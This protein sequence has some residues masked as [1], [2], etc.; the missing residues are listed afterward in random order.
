MLI[1][2]I[3][4]SLIIFK[5]RAAGLREEAEVGID[6]QLGEIV[7]EV[8]ARWRMLSRSS[9]ISGMLSQDFFQN[10]CKVEDT[11]QGQTKIAWDC[12]RTGGG[13]SQG[14][15]ACEEFRLKISFKILKRW[16]MLS[17][18]SYV[19]EVLPQDFS[20]LINTM[21]CLY[22]NTPGENLL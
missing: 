1:T 13:C 21:M 2:K 5:P 3:L 22:L 7:C 19:W 12:S 10:I 8:S 15:A 4:P 20:R 14:Q 18:S 9:C 11:C 16:R 17:R 6:P